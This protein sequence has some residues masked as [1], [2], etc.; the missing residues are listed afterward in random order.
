MS[1]IPFPGML[2][3]R[4]RRPGCTYYLVS[5]GAQIE[6]HLM[7]EDRGWGEFL[8]CFPTWAEALGVAETARR[9]GYA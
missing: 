7:N 1:V 8:G 2:R 9:E 6:V 4:D 3:L 5:D